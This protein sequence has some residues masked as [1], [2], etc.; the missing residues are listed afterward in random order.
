MDFDRFLMG[1]LMILNDL[2]LIF[3]GFFVDLWKLFG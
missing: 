3:D 1:F 2:K